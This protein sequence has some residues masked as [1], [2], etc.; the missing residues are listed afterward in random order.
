M[1]NIL[2]L[3]FHLVTQKDSRVMQSEALSMKMIAVMTLIFMPLGTVASIFGSQLIKLKD[4]EPYHMQVSQDFWLVW[5]IAVPLTVLVVVIW[6]VWYHD[7]RA[8]LIDKIPP[9]EEGDHGYFG[10][11][12]FKESFRGPKRRHKDAVHIV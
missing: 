6:R 11:K 12:S 1:E 7:A 5:L 4:E 8:Q 9:R 10:W 2:Q 3:S